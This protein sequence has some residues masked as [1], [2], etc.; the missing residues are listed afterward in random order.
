MNLQEIY[1]QH[2]SFV[3]RTVRRLGVSDAEAADAVQDV[4]LQAHTHLEQFEGRASI[5]TW[6]FTLCRT[7]ARERRQRAQRSRRLL[8]AVTSEETIDLRADVGRAAEHN[9]RLALLEEL[10]GE[11]DAEPRT[12]FVLFELEQLSG[13]EIAELLG[14]PLGTVYSRLQLAR[15]SF[16]QALGRRQARDAFHLARAGVRP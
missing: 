8:G 5:A 4:F 16:R 14:I 15:S 12:V 2:A 11:L 10:L 7:V 13:Q 3:W 6:L 9:Q 1:D